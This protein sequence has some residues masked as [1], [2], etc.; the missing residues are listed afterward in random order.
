LQHT[1][2]SDVHAH[3]DSLHTAYDAS[4]QR[5]WCLHAQDSVE[6]NTFSQLQYIIPQ[7]ITHYHSA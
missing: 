6:Q 1:K 7:A 2:Q 4:H 5:V 3:V